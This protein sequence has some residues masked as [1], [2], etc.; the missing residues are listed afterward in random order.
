MILAGP[1]GLRRSTDGGDTFDTVTDRDAVKAQL[2]AI[3]RAG[4]TTLFASGRRDVLRST[5]GGKA[6]TPPPQARPRARGR[7]PHREDGFLLT[8]KGAL[9]RTSNAARSGRRC[10]PWAPTARPGWRS[11]RP[12][13]A[14]W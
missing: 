6:W 4:S 10:P 11:P 8:D 7:L 9:F 14:T 5:D 12:R 13:A 1:R 3:D 2:S